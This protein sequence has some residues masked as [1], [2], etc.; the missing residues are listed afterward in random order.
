VR[1]INFDSEV[2]S[3][4]ERAKDIVLSVNENIKVQIKAIT[5]TFLSIFVSGKIQFSIPLLLCDASFN[6]RKPAA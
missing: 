5:R 2:A 1:N 6:G 3:G 4:T